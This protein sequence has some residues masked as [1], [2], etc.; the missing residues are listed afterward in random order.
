M[1]LINNAYESITGRGRV[2]LTVK[3]TK[4]NYVSIKD[5]GKG[6]SDEES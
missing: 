2:V 6:I 1:H 3:L 5:T 4:S